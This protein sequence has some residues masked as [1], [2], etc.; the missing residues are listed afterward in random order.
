[1]H[2]YNKTKVI[3]IFYRKDIL[4]LHVPYNV[5]YIIVTSS[6]DVSEYE[7]EQTFLFIIFTTIHLL[8]H[9]LYAH[10]TLSLY[11][12]FDMKGQF[13]NMYFIELLLDIFLVKTT[14]EQ[15]KHTGQINIS[16]I[17]T[18]APCSF[19]IYRNRQFFHRH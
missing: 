3:H 4:T 5:H 18:N 2:T 16:S 12:S 19:S 15:S 13:L 8:L 1:M 7:I 14:A 9:S 10:N 11:L 6:S 17:L